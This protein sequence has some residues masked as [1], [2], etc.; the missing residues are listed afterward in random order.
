MSWRVIVW[1]LAGA[2]AMTIAG[3]AIFMLGTSC[4]V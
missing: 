3:G 1:I 2:V 4:S